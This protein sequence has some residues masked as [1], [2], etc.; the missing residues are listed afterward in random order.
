MAYEIKLMDSF[1]FV[2]NAL[3]SGQVREVLEDHEHW[4]LLEQDLEDGLFC[5]QWDWV[6][7]DTLE[8]VLKML[9]EAGC[10]EDG[11]SLAISEDSQYWFYVVEDGRLLVADALS[12]QRRE[13]DLA[14]EWKRED[15]DGTAG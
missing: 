9:V 14:V 8:N 11:E 13:F 5:F 15:H 1:S 6:T 3:E 12:G 7:M 4:W 2:Q 10:L